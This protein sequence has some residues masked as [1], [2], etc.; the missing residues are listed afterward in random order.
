MHTPERLEFEEPIWLFPFEF[1]EIGQS[2]F[3]PTLKPAHMIYVVNNRAKMAEVKVRTFISTKDGCL[4]V[5][6]WRIG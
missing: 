6:V 2:F 5:R 1:M 3:I 4:G